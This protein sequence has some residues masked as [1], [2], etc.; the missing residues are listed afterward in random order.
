MLSGAIPSTWALALAFFEELDHGCATT[1]AVAAS[2]Q[3]VKAKVKA[4]SKSAKPQVQWKQQKTQYKSQPVD[5][6][7]QKLSDIT[8]QLI[9]KTE[10]QLFEQF[11]DSEVIDFITL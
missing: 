5:N 11:F 3:E 1:A 10:V 2:T 4:P 8:S 6:H 7:K 9:D